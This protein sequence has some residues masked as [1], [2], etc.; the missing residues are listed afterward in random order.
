MGRGVGRGGEGRAVSWS[1][2]SSERAVPWSERRD[3]IFFFCRFLWMDFS[4]DSDNWRSLWG[5]GK[6]RVRKLIMQIKNI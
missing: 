6:G 2:S 5:K 3:N 4:T 1:N